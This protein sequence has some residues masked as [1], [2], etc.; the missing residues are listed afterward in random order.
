MSLRSVL[1]LMV[2]TLHLCAC[3]DDP[4]RRTA[5]DQMEQ[6]HAVEVETMG[7]GDGSM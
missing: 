1:A 2:L 5:I 3:S 6:R 7:G 4:D